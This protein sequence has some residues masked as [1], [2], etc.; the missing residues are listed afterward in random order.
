MRFLFGD[1]YRG[2][3]QQ[4]IMRR[5]LDIYE[6]SKILNST[7][8]DEH[9]RCYPK[10]DGTGFVYDPSDKMTADNIQALTED[11]T[12]KLESI[13]T[14]FSNR[15][16]SSY[17]NIEGTVLSRFMVLFIQN[18]DWELA[19]RDCELISRHP[20]EDEIKLYGLDSDVAIFL[21]PL[22]TQDDEEDSEEDGEED[23]GVMRSL[24]KCVF[25]HIKDA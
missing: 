12:D 17:P 5:L 21:P 8:S 14:M 9:F 13:E 22:D 23:S 2:I 18:K 1:N 24:P 10:T 3:A 20:S 15:S 19:M 7:E 16:A 6:I 11:L 4:K 25:K